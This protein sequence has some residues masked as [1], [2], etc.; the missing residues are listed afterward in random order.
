[1]NWSSKNKNPEEKMTFL[2]PDFK[3]NAEYLSF[4]NCGKQILKKNQKNKT[5]VDNIY[6]FEKSHY[7]CNSYLYGK[8][9]SNS[10]F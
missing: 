5:N 8:Y 1:M 3:Y 7:H 9:R 2:S 6:N 4:W 10:E